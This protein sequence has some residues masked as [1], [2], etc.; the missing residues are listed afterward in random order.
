[1]K[2][3]QVARWLYGCRWL[4]INLNSAEAYRGTIEVC[5]L[6]ELADYFR[7]S[8]EVDSFELTVL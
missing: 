3:N 1:V 2:N 6:R 7:D 5:E 8:L 4:K